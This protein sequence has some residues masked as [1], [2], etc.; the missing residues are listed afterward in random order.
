MPSLP[1]PLYLVWATSWQ[2]AL[3]MVF[4]CG[5]ISLIITLTNVRKMIIESIPTALRSA[6][7]AGIGIFLAYVGIKNAG[8]LK[9]TIDPH[10]YTVVGEGADKA[11]ATISANA[12]AV[13]GLVDFNNPAVL[14][15][16]VGLAITYFL[17]CQRS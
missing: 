11:N 1:L 5:V 10:T 3:G 9:F 2:E 13:P 15:A 8:F 14:L 16:L 7:S 4:I 17:C 6:I 12:S